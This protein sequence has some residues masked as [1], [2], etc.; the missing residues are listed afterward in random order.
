MRLL[1]ILAPLLFLAC[2]ACVSTGG[3]PDGTKI[4]AAT[5]SPLMRWIEPRLGVTMTA[6]AV[7]ASRTSFA[8]MMGNSARLAALAKATYVP[9]MIFLDHQSWDPTN[10]REKSYL[11]HELVHHAQFLSKRSYPC[12]RAQEEEAYRLQN[13]WLIENGERPIVSESWIREMSRCDREDAW[14]R[15]S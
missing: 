15:Q 4:D 14:R 13:Q 6:P 12:H 5:L 1:R 7:V 2:T 10:I 8:A 3:V 11:L 9:G